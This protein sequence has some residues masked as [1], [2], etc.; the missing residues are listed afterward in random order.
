MSFSTYELQLLIAC[1]KIAFFTSQYP[2]MPNSKT[3]YGI[4]KCV[5]TQV[6]RKTI[7]EK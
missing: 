7:N 1:L 4:G 3:V 2:D 6:Y 5:E